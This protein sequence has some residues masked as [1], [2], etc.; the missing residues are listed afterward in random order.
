MKKYLIFI[1]A[2]IFSCTT[3]IESPE[4]IL[5]RFFNA[6]INEESSSSYEDD[7]GGSGYEGNTSSPS[8]RSSSSNNS[9]RSSSSGSVSSSSRVSSSSI[10]PSTNNGGPVSYYGRLKASGKYIVG[11]K[12]NTPV[13]VRGVSLFWS[14]TGWGGEKFFTAATV[15]A[16]VDSW[17]AEIIR[18][19]MGASISGTEQYYGSYAAD[20]AGNMA[21]VTTA[22]DAAIA[23]GVYVI[24]DWHSHNAHVDEN[25]SI[26]FFTEM[27]QKYGSKDHVIFEIYNEPKCS[28]GQDSYWCDNDKK[29][30]TTWAQIKTYAEKIIPVIRSNGGAN[31]LILVGTPYFSAAVAAAAGNYLSDNNVGYV[32]HFYAQSHKMNDYAP[33]SWSSTYS[34]GVTTVLNAGKPV[35]VTE[36]GTT[37]ADGGDPNSDNYDSHDVASSNA[38]H[39]FMDNNKISSCAWNVGDKYEGSAFFGTFA[40][41]DAFDMSSWATTSKMTPS[42]Q[43]I[44]NKL[45]TYASS[46]PWRSGSGSGGGT[47][48]DSGSGGGGG[49]GGLVCDY[50]PVNQ[51]GGGCFQIKDANDCDLEW[52]VVKSSCP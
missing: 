23:K 46:A 41:A 15:N 50:G 13:Q 20:K 25:N 16:M 6:S 48:S 30:W 21:R 17:K 37:N 24:I 11:S 27:A 9:N 47:S 19:P 26:E 14:N 31:S 42:G 35:F 12:T 4:S 36:Y 49:G 8:N 32:F 39:T 7:G 29:T 40:G 18:V 28:D 2:L 3:E 52:G 10:T 33:P 5:E 1:A 34:D 51:W 43:Y 45:N 38:W 22:I 44:Y